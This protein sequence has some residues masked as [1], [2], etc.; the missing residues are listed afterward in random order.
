MEKPQVF[1]SYRKINKQTPQIAL[2][3]AKHL[4]E[5]Y[6]YEVF[7]D[8]LAMRTADAWRERIY[9]NIRRSDVVILLLRKDT[10]ESDWVQREVD[11]A[12]GAG[13]SILPLRVDDIDSSE[14]LE[15]AEKLAIGD[16]QHSPFFA[17]LPSDYDRLLDDIRRLRKD[18]RRNQRAFFD[19]LTRRWRPTPPTVS[20][21]RYRTFR[22]PE[23]PIDCLIHLA[24]G[25]MLDMEHFD[26]IV[27]SENDYMQM[28][29]Y[30][31]F[32]ALSSRLRALGALVE[33]GMTLEDT[34]QEHLNE[35]LKRGR[36]KR[37]VAL[38]HVLVTRAGHPRSEL[39]KIAHLVFHASTVRL[40]AGELDESVKPIS[41]EGIKRTVRNCLQE[42]I[43]QNQ[44]GGADLPSTDEDHDIQ[45]ISSIVFPMIGTGY[46][47]RSIEEVVHPIVEGV[48]SFLQ[49]H[50]ESEHLKPLRHI[51]LCAYTQTDAEVLE[52]ALRHHFTQVR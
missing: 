7:L 34:L 51:Y 29:R 25:D 41:P 19:Q 8:T 45:P 28:A 6:G 47:E 5:A 9:D 35:Q 44:T 23:S 50:C 26:V 18:T 24:L 48:H 40:A 49:R 11:F 14:L 27:N 39:R 10:A 15:A 33:G 1:I 3:I 43:H 4:T 17:G 21:P 42:V 12:R 46:G 30:Y 13:V 16:L 20:Q 38:T 37:P 22:L 36:I 52:G 32:T 2:D 31:E